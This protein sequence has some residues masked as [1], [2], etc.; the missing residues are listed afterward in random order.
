MWESDVGQILIYLREGSSLS[1]KYAA[2]GKGLGDS[3]TRSGERNRIESSRQPSCGS[4]IE[5]ETGG[6]DVAAT[7]KKPAPPGQVDA[8]LRRCCDLAGWDNIHR[9]NALQYSD[10]CIP[11]HHHSPIQLPVQNDRVAIDVRNRQYLL[12]GME[13]K[14]EYSEDKPLETGQTPAENPCSW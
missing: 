14:N 4:R 10:C 1:R 12:S 8:G 9:A 13:L 5:T 7:C 2:P 3:R 11:G 6:S